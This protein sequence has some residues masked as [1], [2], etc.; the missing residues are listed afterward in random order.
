MMIQVEGLITNITGITDR[1]VILPAGNVIPTVDATVVEWC[2]KGAV[3]VE[4]MA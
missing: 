2:R 1:Q 4:L 3:T